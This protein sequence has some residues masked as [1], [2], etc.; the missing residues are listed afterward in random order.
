[1]VIS[2]TIKPSSHDF[3]PGQTQGGSLVQREKRRVPCFFLRTWDL[4]LGGDL[5][6]NLRFVRFGGG[7]LQTFFGI[8]T[9]KNWGNGIQFDGCI[10]FNRVVQ[11]PPS[12]DFSWGIC[13]L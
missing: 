2:E 12:V 5:G 11:P 9:P 1:M 6:R 8:F 10:V 4:F 7:K 3:Q 13:L